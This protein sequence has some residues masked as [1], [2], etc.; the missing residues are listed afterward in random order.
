[1]GLRMRQVGGGHFKCSAA[2]PV[3]ACQPLQNGSCH[4]ASFDC[5]GQVYTCC[6]GSGVRSL[7]CCGPSNLD[8]DLGF[9]RRDVAPCTPPSLTDFFLIRPKQWP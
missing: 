7:R 8:L 4:G 6:S 2:N 9:L 3:L 1:M 5:W